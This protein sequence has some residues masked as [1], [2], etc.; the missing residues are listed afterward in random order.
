MSGS[1]EV[2]IYIDCGGT[3]VDTA[4]LRECLTV[5]GLRPLHVEPCEGNVFWAVLPAGTDTVWVQDVLNSML[6]RYC[7]R[8]VQVS[9]EYERAM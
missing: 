1:S 7:T 8:D 9:R 2:S 3:A 5:A 6:H 4:E